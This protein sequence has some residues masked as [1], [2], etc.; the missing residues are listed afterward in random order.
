MNTGSSLKS[1]KDA[2]P[3]RD[4][5]Y[6]ALATHS[7]FMVFILIYNSPNYR[8]ISHEQPESHLSLRHNLPDKGAASLQKFITPFHVIL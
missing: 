1:R 6:S 7:P 2:K 4:P 5:Q 8:A 3:Q